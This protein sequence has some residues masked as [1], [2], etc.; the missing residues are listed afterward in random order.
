MLRA[1]VV[2][3]FFPMLRLVLIAAAIG[4][5]C[6]CEQRF[7]AT[8]P[9]RP[10]TAGASSSDA[11]DAL[12][13]QSVSDAGA[14]RSD[15]SHAMSISSCSWVPQDCVTADQDASTDAMYHVVSGSG[16]GVV[17]TREQAM[18]DL[19]RELRDRIDAGDRLTVR[20]R[21]RADLGGGAGGH[22][23]STTPSKPSSDAVAQAA[24]RLLDAV[25]G[26]GE[27]LVDVHHHSRSSC[28]LSLEQP[29]GDGGVSQC[30]INEPERPHGRGRGGT[31]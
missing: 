12:L 27:L 17:R 20:P 25:D 14:P 10:E 1:A 11:L 9:L 3:R 7:S 15:A 8:P 26:A 18:T 5:P 4:A 23:P 2:L 30:L 22:V 6:A 29:M 21:P 19:Y 31:R 16:R 13:R 28:E 24:M